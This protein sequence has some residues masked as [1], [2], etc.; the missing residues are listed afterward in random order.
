MSQPDT[1]PPPIPRRIAWLDTGR[2]ITRNSDGGTTG[3]SLE[4]AKRLAADLTEMVHLLGGN[5]AR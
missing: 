3:R 4:D 1:T 5:D 2:I